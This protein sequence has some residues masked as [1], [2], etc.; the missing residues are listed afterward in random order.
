V[1][2]VPNVVIR[3]SDNGEDIRKF[4]DSQVEEMIG[5]RRLLHGRVSKTL[6]NKIIHKLA[7][8]AQGM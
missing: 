7:D 1:S 2:T 8:G 4:V 3:A 6:K 5:T